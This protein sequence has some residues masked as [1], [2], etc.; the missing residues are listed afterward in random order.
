MN[1]L[2][3]LLDGVLLLHVL[4][5]HDQPVGDG[6]VALVVAAL[7]S[8]LNFVRLNSEFLKIRKRRI[9]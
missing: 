7:K 4:V 2:L 3:E 1:A 9:F 5:V 6:Q 8:L